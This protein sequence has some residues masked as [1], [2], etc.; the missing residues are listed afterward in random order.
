[1]HLDLVINA[2]VYIITLF[3]LQY[4]KT[5]HVAGKNSNPR[6]IASKYSKYMQ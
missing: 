6:K 1:M 4:N 2:R 5:I 3:L